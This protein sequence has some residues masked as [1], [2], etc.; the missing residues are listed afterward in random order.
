MFSLTLFWV[1]LWECFWMGSQSLNMHG[2][3]AWLTMAWALS[4]VTLW[5]PA[6][7]HMWLLRG[8]PGRQVPGWSGSQK[9]D[10]RSLPFL[11][12]LIVLLSGK[13]WE[14][15]VLC[16]KETNSSCVIP[17]DDVYY[18][19]LSPYAV[20]ISKSVA[21]LWG[22]VSLVLL[23]YVMGM[24]LPLMLQ[25]SFQRGAMG[26]WGLFPGSP[27]SE[28]HWALDE[29]KTWSLKDLNAQSEAYK[30]RQDNP[31]DF[32]WLKG[33]SVDKESVQ[34]FIIIF[35]IILEHKFFVIT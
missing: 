32:G 28:H 14:R 7:R 31:C 21:L 1:Y 17:I 10:W 29:N 15:C 12:I 22:L 5:P 25:P 8:Q 24:Q 26:F 19:P 27:V 33:I 6:V 35:I 34:H 11:V 13:T 20:G 16:C 3:A 2:P 9:V 18:C 23:A 30:K 4:D